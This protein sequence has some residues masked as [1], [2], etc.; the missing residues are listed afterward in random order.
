MVMGDGGE[1]HW[2]EDVADHL[3]G[4]YLRYSFTKGTDQEVDFLVDCLA[5]NPGAR[6]LDVGCGPGRHAHAFGRRG[7]EVV[8]VDISE[9]FI[10]LARDNT[11]PGTAVA[12]ERADARALTFES[13]FDVVISLCQG[14]FGLSAGG[15]GEGEGTGSAIRDAGAAPLDPDRAVLQGMARALR[16]GGRLALSAFS[17]YF[18]VRFLGEADS[19]DAERGV[20]HEHTAVRNEAGVEVPA[21]LWTTC[22]TPRELRLLAEAAGLCPEHIWSVAPGDYAARPPDTD[23]PEFVLVAIRP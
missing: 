11:P 8:G 10:A 22:F 1:R 19:F 17:A 18:Q 21:D 23:H 7:F 2:F 5:L 13:E 20:N 14:A 12:F 15:P 6:I 9:R 4:A 3:G 16:P